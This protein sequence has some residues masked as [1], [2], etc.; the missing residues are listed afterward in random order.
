MLYIAVIVLEIVL[1]DMLEV[2]VWYIIF[3]SLQSM[4]PVIIS[5][6][7]KNKSAHFK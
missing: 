3:V 5:K 2:P 6:Q 1:T 7:G 4:S